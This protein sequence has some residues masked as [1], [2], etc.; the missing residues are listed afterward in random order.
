MA[1]KECRDRDV[2]YKA[3]NNRITIDL[4]RSISNKV[5]RSFLGSFGVTFSKVKTIPCVIFY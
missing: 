3:A 4:N 2:K 5:E 1:R